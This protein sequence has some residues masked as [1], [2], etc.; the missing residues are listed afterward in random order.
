M[1][2][3]LPF[4]Q[5]RECASPRSALLLDWPDLRQVR[6]PLPTWGMVGQAHHSLDARFA[7]SQSQS[8]LRRRDYMRERRAILTW[9]GCWR[10]W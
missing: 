7:R 4:P 8:P 5:A 10:A 9:G 6:S 1:R 2:T 3:V